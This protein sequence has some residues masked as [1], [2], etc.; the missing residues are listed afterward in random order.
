VIVWL[1]LGGL[2]VALMMTFAVALALL[3][4]MRLRATAR[5]RRSWPFDAL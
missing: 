5:V 1:L 3:A 4:R 2:V